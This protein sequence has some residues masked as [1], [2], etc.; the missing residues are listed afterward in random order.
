ML[1][2]LVLKA[3][4]CCCAPLYYWGQ[5]KSKSRDAREPAAAT[6][7]RFAGGEALARESRWGG[8]GAGFQVSFACMVRKVSV[9]AECRVLEERS[10]RDCPKVLG[11]SNCEK[12]DGYSWEN[13]G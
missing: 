8:E 7:A 9:L 4:F 11:F 2:S 10:I 13:T 6:W 1:W 3:S 5:N 12:G